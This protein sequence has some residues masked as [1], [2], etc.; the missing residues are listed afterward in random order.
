MGTDRSLE[1]AILREDWPLRQGLPSAEGS[2]IPV[3]EWTATKGTPRDQT[4]TTT[5]EQPTDQLP[6]TIM[7]P[8]STK[9]QQ[10]AVRQQELQQ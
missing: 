10:P 1:I 2:C 8:E 9:S 7:E 3:R 4:T 6:T 5:E